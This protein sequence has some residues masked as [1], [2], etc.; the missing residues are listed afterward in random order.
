[1]N[2]YQLHVTV[3]LQ[4]KGVV[5]MRR[6]KIEFWDDGYWITILGFF[7]VDDVVTVPSS[8]ILLYCCWFGY[9][10]LH[11]VLFFK[12]RSVTHSLAGRVSHCETFH[13]FFFLFKSKHSFINKYLDSWFKLAYIFVFI[14]VRYWKRQSLFSFVFLSF[15]FSRDTNVEMQSR[16]CLWESGQLCKIW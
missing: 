15:L 5:K 13:S 10:L 14:Q 9:N 6:T 7:A 3:W 4:Q 16:D 2:Y 1:M 8:T 12:K 11:L